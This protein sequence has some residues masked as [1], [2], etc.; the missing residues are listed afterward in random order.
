MTEHKL[1]LT[2]SNCIFFINFWL[3]NFSA[4]ISFEISKFWLL[5]K[6]YWV[7]LGSQNYWLDIILKLL[8]L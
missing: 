3:T 7:K 2:N 1:V 8:S 4:V 5:V 6:S